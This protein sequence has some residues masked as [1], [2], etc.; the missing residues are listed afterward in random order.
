MKKIRILLVD[1]HKVLREGLKLLLVGE[2]DLE[3]IGEAGTVDEAI[4]L[5][6]ELEPDVVVM[7][8]SLPGGGGLKAIKQILEKKFPVKIVVLSMHSNREL[9]MEAIELGS[10]GYVP[11]SSAHVSLLS[12]IRVVHAGERF[13]DPVAATALVEELL[14]KKDHS[15]LLKDLS[16]RET[17]V[18]K[19]TAM[20]FTSREIGE[21]LSLSPKTIETYRQRVMD[22][23]RF[24][25]RSELV[26]FALRTGLLA[27]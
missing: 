12:A 15:Q 13:L 14:E 16:D 8:L 24:E 19:F 2:E 1:D 18:L 11:K 7:D 5:T 21:K 10:D 27:E 23:M 17:E 9:V 20:G 25:H 4:R 3:V 26:Q 22:K 6:E